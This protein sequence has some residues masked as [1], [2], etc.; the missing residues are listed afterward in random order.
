M[1]ETLGMV[2]KFGIHF[3]K[4]I[5]ETATA[6]DWLCGRCG[7]VVGIGFLGQNPVS[8]LGSQGSFLVVAS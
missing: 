4:I 6:A 1:P 5:E 3:S 2:G 8:P 7:I